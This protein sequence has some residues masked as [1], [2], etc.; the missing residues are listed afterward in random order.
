MLIYICKYCARSF[1]L[2]IHHLVTV[3]LREKIVLTLLSVR[4]YI[5]TKTLFLLSNQEIEQQQSEFSN[6]LKWLVFAI[7]TSCV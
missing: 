3:K 7:F 2:E 1:V 5:F 6:V 4:R